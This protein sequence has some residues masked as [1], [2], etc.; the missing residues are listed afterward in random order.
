MP[1]DRQSTLRMPSSSRSS[2]SHSMTVRSGMAAFSMGTSSHSGPWVMTMPP[3]CCDR[4]RGKPTSSPTSATSRPP[5]NESGSMPASRQRSASCA[6]RWWPSRL[7]GQG[8]DAIERQAQGLAHVADGRAGAI[9]DDLGG[10]AGPLAAVLV[11]EYCST[12]S[13]PLVLEID[14]DV[15]GL[16]ALAADEA[17]E[18]HV[19]PVGIDRRHAQAIADGRVGRRAASLAQNARLRAKRTRSKTVRK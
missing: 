15:G 6:S 5:R 18:Q 16:V 4:C 13:R 2:L 11:V 19:D 9:G 1:S 8:V 14:V 17:L 10:H 7:F 12:S 3:T